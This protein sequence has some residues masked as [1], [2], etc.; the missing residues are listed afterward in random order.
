[1]QLRR[2][3][4]SDLSK[5]LLNA[6][7]LHTGGGVQVASSIVQE[8][9]DLV[10]QQDDIT[11]YISTEVDKNVGGLL[12]AVAPEFQY[13]VLDVSGLAVR[14]TEARRKMDGFQTVFT[15]FGPLYRWSPPF[16]SI[17]GF[18]Q[19][20]IIYPD[21][22]CYARMRLHTRLRTK[23]KFWIQSQFFKRADVIVVELAHV[24]D[25]LVRYLG[26]PVEK[27]HVVHNCLSS[28]YHSDE[29][30]LPL[31]MPAADCD[32]R[33]G[34]LGRNYPHKNTAV[35]SEIARI[36]AAEHAIK[37]KFYVTFTDEEWDACTPELRSVCVNVGPI[38]VH[39]CPAFY[40]GLDAIVFPSLL[41]CFSAT[42][43]ETMA[44]GLPLFASDRPFNRDACGEHATYFD[45]MVPETAATAIA[46]YFSG[47][48]HAG[49]SL[50]AARNHALT[51]SSAKDRAERYLD[52]MQNG[53]D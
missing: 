5:L 35:F 3:G 32:L 46:A 26:I 23:L 53:F 18:A 10:A 24:R 29:S 9:T 37:A 4:S 7:N 27:I 25:G 38:D 45:P 20:W 1:V 14:N 21:N 22:E 36:L 50:E 11:A 28:L 42:P 6:S 16:K 13:D 47:G 2:L 41:E 43:L 15:V 34:F 48:E 19:P 39:Q 8:F 12:T 17:V 33:L 51:F 52:L 44:M 31:E 30:W 40:Q 49:I